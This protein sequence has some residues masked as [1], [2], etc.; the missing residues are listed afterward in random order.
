MKKEKASRYDKIKALTLDGM[1]EFLSFYFS[2]D[3]CPAKRDNCS[4]NDAMHMDAIRAYL[5]E[6]GN[7]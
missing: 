2:C 7:L 4:E 1:T 3:S 6:D 5:K